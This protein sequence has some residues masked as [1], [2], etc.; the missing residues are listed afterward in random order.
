MGEHT[1]A[2]RMGIEHCTTCGTCRRAD[3]RNEP[4][5]GKLP[6]IKPRRLIGWRVRWEWFAPGGRWEPKCGRLVTLSEARR[7]VQLFHGHT[8]YRNVRI[9]R[10]YRRTR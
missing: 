2:T 9:L 10:V 5:R 8:I 1:W 4:C 3:G 7:H 6:P